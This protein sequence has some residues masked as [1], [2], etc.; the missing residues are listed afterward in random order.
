MFC[1]DLNGKE[2]G[3]KRGKKDKRKIYA[4]L[5]K[6]YSRESDISKAKS[7]GLYD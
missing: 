5:D 2:I 3:K 6:H 4:T 7:V 1:G